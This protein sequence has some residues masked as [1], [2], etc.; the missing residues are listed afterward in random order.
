MKFAVSL[1]R[2]LCGLVAGVLL[3]AYLYFTINYEQTGVSGS[4]TLALACLFLFGAALLIWG[5]LA[6]MSDVWLKRIDNKEFY[7]KLLQEGNV[8]SVAADLAATGNMK[9]FGNLLNQIN[10]AN[11]DSKQTLLSGFRDLSEKLQALQ[12]EDTPGKQSPLVDEV[13]TISQNMNDVQTQIEALLTQLQQ[14]KKILSQLSDYPSRLNNGETKFYP[15]LRE[16]ADYP[17]SVIDY[18][19]PQSN[20]DSIS[21]NDVETPI[22]SNIEIAEDT[23]DDEFTLDTYT[24][25]SL[26][27]LLNSENENSVTNIDLPQENEIYNLNE[28][29]FATDAAEDLTTPTDTSADLKTEDTFDLSEATIDLGEAEPDFASVL[30]EAQTDDDLG[31]ENPFGVE[32]SPSYEPERETTFI[33]PEQSIDLGAE[34]PFGAS[35]DTDSAIDIKAIEPAVTAKKN[36]PNLEQIFND[37]LAS[38]LADL[39]ILNGKPTEK[40]QDDIDLEQFFASHR[41]SI[42]G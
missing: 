8:G 21:D 27:D 34:N 19:E 16:E 23:K 37:E 25:E 4:H 22:D 28:E 30:P 2:L 1:V 3:V 41:K 7:Q 26:D 40:T 20:A 11:E 24:D 15:V 42:D 38:E 31:A 13:R 17:E 9:Q 10:A 36:E 14:Q 29:G 32:N 6:V 39:E 18:N 12:N 35:E 5:G 33:E